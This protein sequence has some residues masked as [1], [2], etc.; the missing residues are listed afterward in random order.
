MICERPEI[1]F[2]FIHNRQK[3]EEKAKLYD[4]MTKGDFPGQYNVQS[5]LTIIVF[6]LFFCSC[7]SHC[8]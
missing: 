5:Y 1:S 6:L 8:D 2:T 3:L 7:N 4:Q